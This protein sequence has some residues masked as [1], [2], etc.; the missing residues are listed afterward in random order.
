VGIR[1]FEIWSNFPPKQKGRA[2]CAKMAACAAKQSQIGRKN[3]NGLPKWH[4]VKFWGFVYSGI[5]I[6]DEG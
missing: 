6:V 1:V 5:R 2:D 3:Q 4:V